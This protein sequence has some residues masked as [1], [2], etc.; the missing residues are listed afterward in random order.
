M[1]VYSC[2]AHRIQEPTDSYLFR[3]PRKQHELQVNSM[4]LL[5]N[6]TPMSLSH[7]WSPHPSLSQ[8]LEKEAILV[9]GQFLLCLGCCYVE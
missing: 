6:Q 3:V 5:Y 4:Q 8:C 1:W 9:P 2:D 7:C